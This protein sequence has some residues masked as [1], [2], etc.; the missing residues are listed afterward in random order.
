MKKRSF[1]VAAG[2]CVMAV[3]IACFD[4]IYHKPLLP[5][6]TIKHVYT[7]RQ[8]IQMAQSLDCK[9]ALSKEVRDIVEDYD[10]SSLP[11]D[12]RAFVLDCKSD[13]YER[14]LS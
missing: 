11:Q 14:R 1:L 12:V 3:S 10:L 7:L 9:V 4:S 6:A 5:D 2:L 8:K 13:K